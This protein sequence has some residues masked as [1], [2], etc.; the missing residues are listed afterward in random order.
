VKSRLIVLLVYVAMV[1][2]LLR[3]LGLSWPDGHLY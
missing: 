2:G 3:E 1:A